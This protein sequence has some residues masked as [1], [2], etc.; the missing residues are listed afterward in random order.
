VIP[1]IGLSR[2]IYVAPTRDEAYADAE[3]GMRRYAQVMA[4]R[5]GVDPS[6][7]VPELLARSDIHIGSPQ[8]VIA[9]LRTDRLLAHATDLIL[10]VHP[11]DP[12]QDKT[13]RSFE[14]IA[15]HVAP[16]LG[17]RPRPRTE[18]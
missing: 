10:Q 6:L 14:L 7:P 15:R 1:R 12:E 13:L 2:S 11:I 16:A 18:C 3:S 9:S 5:E 8:D 4:Q 17:W